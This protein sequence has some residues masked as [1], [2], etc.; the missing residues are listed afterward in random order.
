MAKAEVE[1]FLTHL[2]VEGRRRS[3]GRNRI[4]EQF[5]VTFVSSCREC[6]VDHGARYEKRA[7]PQVLR[8]SFATHLLESV[9]VIGTVRE[10]LDHNN[11]TTT[12]IQTGC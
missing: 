9:S 11:V 3:A 6:G 5:C 8:H 10:L 4:A 7:T 12:Q 2:A 1:A